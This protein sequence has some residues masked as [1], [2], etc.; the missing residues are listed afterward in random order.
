MNP[1]DSL[2]S[3]MS[4]LVAFVPMLG[5]LVFVHE[6]G[7]TLGCH[8]DIDNANTPGYFPDSHGWRWSTFRSV[9]SY[10]PG[11]RTLHCSDPDV[12]PPDSGLATGLLDFAD[13]VRTIEETA[14]LMAE[15]RTPGIIGQGSTW[16]GEQA[17]LSIDLEL[18]GAPPN[19]P[20]L[21]IRSDVLHPNSL[22]LGT[23]YLGSFTR[24]RMLTTDDTGSVQFP[25]PPMGAGYYQ[26][27]FRNIGDP[28][29]DCGIAMT[30]AV[31][32]E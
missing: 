7:H 18:S 31:R 16:Q 6:L 10:S 27:L 12:L 26:A 24:V 15:F 2:L 25:V 21:L 13:N 14:P 22:C 23:L 5:I 8:H 17:S 3:F 20:V 29:D 1:L 30:N 19:A 32:R 11:T 4:Y 9:M 28:L